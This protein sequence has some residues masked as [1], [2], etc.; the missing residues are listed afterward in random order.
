MKI[1]N[2]R[3]KVIYETEQ[4]DFIGHVFN[5]DSF[6]LIDLSGAIFDG[7]IMEGC[8]FDE[9]ILAYASFKK[10]DLY[11]ARFYAVNLEHS[12][13]AGASLNGCT[14]CN[15]NLRYVNLADADLSR[16]NVGGSTDLRGANLDN[17]VIYNSTFIGAE[18]DRNTIFPKGF[19]PQAEGMIFTEE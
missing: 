5:E 13:F 4:K 11:W 19:C 17:A 12:N 2:I 14:F 9:T 7:L 15:A 10:C 3:R 18:Y 1:F 6:S 8:I 16:D